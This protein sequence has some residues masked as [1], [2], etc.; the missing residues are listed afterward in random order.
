MPTLVLYDL[1]IFFL[2]YLRGAGKSSNILSESIFDYV[3]CII[4]YSRIL[5][6]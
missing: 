5:A 1:G 6:Q 4:F 2:S 3:A